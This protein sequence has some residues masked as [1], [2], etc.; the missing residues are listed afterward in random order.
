MGST[1][2]PVNSGLQHH[3]V[4]CAAF[5]ALD[6]WVAGRA[7]PPSARRLEPTADGRDLHRDNLG[8]ATG[9]IRTPWTDVPVAVLS[10]TGQRGE[11]FA[12]LFGTTTGLSDA[13]LARLY[14]G[15]KAD[16]LEKFEASLDGA[17]EA[18]FLLADDR[19]EILAVADA[20]WP[21]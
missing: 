20:A 15:G 18:G 13:D 1:P 12:F 19:A 14:P 9:G 17:I 11:M 4:E 5:E 8:I 7:R 10:G 21:G 16:Y 2:L 3:Y 6:S